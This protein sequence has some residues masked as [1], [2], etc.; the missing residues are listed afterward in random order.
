MWRVT[1]ITDVLHLHPRK[2]STRRKTRFPYS[3][4]A[5]SC[6][7]KFKTSLRRHECLW[8]AVVSYWIACFHSAHND[9]NKRWNKPWIA[10]KPP[11]LRLKY[12]RFSIPQ[13]PH[14]YRFIQSFKPQIA[15]YQNQY[16]RRHGRKE[17]PRWFRE[18]S[19]ARSKRKRYR[20]EK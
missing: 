19:N 16:Q 4:A 10:T 12:L 7:S 1:V 3:V 17:R 14:D 9:Q 5:P 20:C 13:N 6:R 15:P 2:P 11:R 8:Q 18:P